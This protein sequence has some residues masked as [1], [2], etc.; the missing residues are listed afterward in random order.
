MIIT[1]HE[2]GELRIRYQ[3]EKCDYIATN[4]IKVV[5]AIFSCNSAGEGNLFSTFCHRQF[6]LLS[7]GKIQQCAAN[8]KPADG[9]V[10]RVSL[11]RFRFGL[12]SHDYFPFHSSTN[13]FIISINGLRVIS[14][15][16]I[17]FFFN[18]FVSFTYNSAMVVV[19]LE[20][21]NAA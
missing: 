8:P 11:S 7:Q 4:A 3:H 18:Y 12:D 20:G 14:F 19:K 17:V 10:D 21:Q 15:L 9:K 6:H 13:S 1:V 16:R 2:L 5:H